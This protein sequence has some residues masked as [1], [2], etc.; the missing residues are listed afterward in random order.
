MSQEIEMVKKGID[1]IDTLTKKI[2]EM[3]EKVKNSSSDDLKKAYETKLKELETSM[4][5]EFA[6]N[7]KDLK[8]KILD[9]E[10][11]S[12][13]DEN[14]ERTI[15]GAMQA[16]KEDLTS[17]LKEGRLFEFS[18]KD[19]PA[20]T[21]TTGNSTSGNVVT[22]Q[23]IERIAHT[24]REALSIESFF[25]Q[26]PIIRDTV[27]GKQE[28]LANSNYNVGSQP[29]Q[30]ELKPRTTIK[31]IPK[32]YN[33]VTIATTL[34]VSRQFLSDF[35]L[36]AA[37]IQS[38]LPTEMR[39]E[40]NRQILYG[41]GVGGGNEELEGLMTQVP[42][43]DY[44]GI[45]DIPGMPTND[46]VYNQDRIY[47]AMHTLT[48]DPRAMFSPDMAL[49]ANEIGTTMALQKDSDGRYLDP[50]MVRGDTARIKGVTPDETNA[51][52][53][54]ASSVPFLVGDTSRTN[55]L[56]REGINLRF[57]EQDEDNVSRNLITIRAER[58][59]GLMNEFPSAYRK[60]NVLDTI[61]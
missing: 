54:T 28:D 32:I 25:T 24:P 35:N 3:E 18:L 5:K 14:F 2:S 60:G 49:I 52:E 36:L 16:K 41:A 7:A 45:L 4:K 56:N 40:V 51:L 12:K 9:L 33:I 37:Y 27:N 34:R 17:K 13:K 44:D 19:V 39:L 11:K 29:G 50:Q 48:K 30:G 46:K 6:E 59:V 38:M 55:I 22:P 53:V 43:V 42:S 23:F 26:L 8:K 61:T 10:G 31:F 47:W 20:N 15:Y 21:M 57:F 58:R 1:K